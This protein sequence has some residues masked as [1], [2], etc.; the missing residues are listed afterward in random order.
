MI[1]GERLRELREE[2]KLSQGDIEKRTG[3]LRCYI[4]RVENGHTVPAVETLEKLARAFEVPLYQLFY[5]GAEPP[6]VPNLL[7]RKSSDE[8]AWGSS[9]REAR[10]LSKLR[11][12]LGKSSDEDRKLIL[13]MAQKMAKR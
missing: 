12:L 4:S 2:K 13:H 10:F 7:K 5:E 3:L 8:G 6:Q 11:R 9:G 1:I